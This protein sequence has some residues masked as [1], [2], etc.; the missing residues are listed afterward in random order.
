[1]GRGEV[2]PFSGRE[3]LSVNV[4]MRL[5]SEMEQTVVEGII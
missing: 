2:Y 5:V 4:C 1:M 3:R